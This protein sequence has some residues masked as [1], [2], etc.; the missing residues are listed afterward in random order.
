MSEGLHSDL[1]SRIRRLRTRLGD[2]TGVRECRGDG[3]YLK[4][5]AKNYNL[6][7]TH[8][9][10]IFPNLPVGMNAFPSPPGG[11]YEFPTAGQFQGYG[12]FR[13]HI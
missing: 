9:S 7:N 11:H 2:F 10:N 8:F 12:E 6:S 1:R 13:F 3:F 4:K 5:T